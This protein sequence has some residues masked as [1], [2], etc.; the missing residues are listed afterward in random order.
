MTEKMKKYLPLIA[1]TLVLLLGFAVR[2]YDLTDA[3]LDWNHIRQMRDATIARS[4]YYQL[5][6]NADP[7]LAQQAQDQAN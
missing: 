3:P 6:P 5:L 2:M 4:I 7:V 1:L